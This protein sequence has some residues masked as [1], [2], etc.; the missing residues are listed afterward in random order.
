MELLEEENA[1]LR[2]RVEL[3]QGGQTRHLQFIGVLE[4]RLDLLA[5]KVDALLEKDQALLE[6]NARLRAGS[7]ASNNYAAYLDV[8][9]CK[10][11]ALLAKNQA[12][13]EEN[14]R[15]RAGSGDSKNYAAYLTDMAGGKLE[16]GKWYMYSDGKLFMKRDTLCDFKHQETKP[17]YDADPTTFVIQAS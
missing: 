12:L 2:A 9:G 15:L 16:I 6:E 7:G 17:A 1:A 4:T 5:C 10:V 11:D 13:E 14:A 3:L 8:L